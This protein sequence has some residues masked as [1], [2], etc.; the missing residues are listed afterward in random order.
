M[1]GARCII[2]CAGELTVSNINVNENEM[3]IAVDGGFDYCDFLKITPDAVIGDF[4]SLSDEGLRKLKV[5][6][7]QGGNVIS[8]PVIKDDTD[9]IYA[10]KYAL[11]EGFKRIELFAASGGRLDHTIAN[12]QTLLFIKEHGALGYLMEGGSM[13]FVIQNEKVSFKNISGMFSVF[14]LGECAKGV[15][16]TGGKYELK[17]GV[18]KDSFPLGISNEF[19]DKPC[20]IRVKEGKLLCI[21]YY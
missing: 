17:D 8:L 5:Y 13:T 6:E 4:D 10:V 16:I 7:E 21:V 9:T 14:S 1:E 3:V 12:I 20:E 15:D 2:I 19:T 18:L 11:E